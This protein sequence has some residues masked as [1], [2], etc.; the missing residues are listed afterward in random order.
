MKELKVKCLIIKFSCGRYYMLRLILYFWQCN[1]HG[2][3]ILHDYR[4]PP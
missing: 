3:H 4:C 2:S 1:T